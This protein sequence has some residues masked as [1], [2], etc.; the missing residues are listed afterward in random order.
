[1]E[2]KPQHT[3]CFGCGSFLVKCK[4]QSDSSVCVLY[5]FAVFTVD[6]S[7]CLEDG[8]VY[9]NRKVATECADP[10]VSQTDVFSDRG[11]AQ[12][13]SQAVGGG[14]EWHCYGPS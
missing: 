4:L 13:D 2:N 9:V 12:A 5:T 7:Q 6:V 11:S 14:G 10:Y 8:A 3:C 1:M